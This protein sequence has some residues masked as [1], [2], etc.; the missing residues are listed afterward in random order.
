MAAI[1]GDAIDCFRK[2]MATQNRRH[3][4][5]FLEAEEWIF[6]DDIASVFSFRNVCDVLGIDPDALRKQAAAWKQ[7]QLREI[8]SSGLLTHS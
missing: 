6:S 1:L 7:S 2:N 5:L 4:R 8:V 3:R